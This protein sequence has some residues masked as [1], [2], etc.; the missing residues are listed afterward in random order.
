MTFEERYAAY[1]Q[2]MQLLEQSLG[3][4]VKPVIKTEQLGDAL[5]TRP[6]LVIVPIQGFIPHASPP[7]GNGTDRVTVP[8]SPEFPTAD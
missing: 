2:G 1:V 3:F 5:L 8:D 4:T 7:D 6:D